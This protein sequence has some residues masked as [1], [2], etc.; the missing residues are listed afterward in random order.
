MK[1]SKIKQARHKLQ[2][3]NYMPEAW[4]N[5]CRDVKCNLWILY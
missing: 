2:K 3:A 5:G 1:I 4:G